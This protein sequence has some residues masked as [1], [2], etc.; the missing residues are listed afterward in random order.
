MHAGEHE[1]ADAAAALG[2]DLEHLGG[3]DAFGE[4]QRLIDDQRAAQRD[5]E[6]HAEDAAEAGDQRGL[7]VR[8]V[9][10]TPEHDERGQREDHA[11]REAFARGGGGLHRVVLE[12]VAACAAARKMPIEI[13]AAGTEADT[14]MPANMPRYAF[15]PARIDRQQA[16]EDDD[17]RRQL[18]QRLRSRECRASTPLPR[19]SGLGTILWESPHDQGHFA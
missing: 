4:L 9:A 16:A 10:S 2:A 3:R 8:E 6:Q 19:Q 14:V 13:T 7:E 11:G 12:D 18:G 5:R 15:A 1:H 17:A